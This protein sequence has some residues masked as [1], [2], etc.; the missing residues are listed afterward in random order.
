MSIAD[1]LKETAPTTAPEAKKE[2]QSLS[3]LNA[4]VQAVVTEMAKAEALL[5]AAK[6]AR[7]AAV[8]KAK[9]IF[10]RTG[11][12]DLEGAEGKVQVITTKGSRRLDLKKVR[13]LL[14]EEQVEDCTTVGASSTR[15]QFTAR[16]AVLT[17]V[18]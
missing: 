13:K 8:A 1:I 15:V 12:E 16:P 14:T 18:K 11:V 2:R 4:E 10:E 9:A 5:A 3:G 7:E 6:A 17:E